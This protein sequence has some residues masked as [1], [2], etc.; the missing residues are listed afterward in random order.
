MESFA[1]FVV[2]LLDNIVLVGDVVRDLQCKIA[3]L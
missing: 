2:Y 1:Y 3:G